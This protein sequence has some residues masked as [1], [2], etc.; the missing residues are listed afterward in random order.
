MA[1]S[2]FLTFCIGFKTL[3]NENIWKHFLF[4]HSAACN[5]RKQI[6]SKVLTLS[7]RG[8]LYHSASFGSLD[9]FAHHLCLRA[10]VYADRRWYL[11][12]HRFAFPKV[13]HS[14]HFQHALCSAWRWTPSLP[15]IV[16]HPPRLFPQQADPK[17]MPEFTAEYRYRFLLTVGFCCNSAFAFQK[18][19]SIHLRA[20]LQ[21]AEALQ[22]ETTWKVR[23]LA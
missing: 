3:N 17:T 15:Y 21:S 18:I 11:G 20:R 10:S 7:Q 22:C 23:F 9:V 4:F 12:M 16:S 2:F 8:I 6:A 14:S 19:M 1:T 13:L 5:W